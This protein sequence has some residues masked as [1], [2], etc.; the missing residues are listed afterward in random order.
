MSCTKF[1]PLASI[2]S[3]SAF[4]F[5]SLSP[6]PLRLASPL[7]RKQ[8]RSSSAH[9]YGRTVFR[10]PRGDLSWRMTSSPDDASS[11][12]ASA[13]S[14]TSDTL[15]DLEPYQN[16]NNL[17]DQV[18]SAMSADGGLK[19]TVA[20]MRNLLN[21]MMIQHTMNAVP[22]DALGRATLCALMASNGMQEEQMFQITMKGDGPLRGCVAIV[23]GKGEARGYVGNPSL[24]DDFTLKEAI[25]AGTVQVVKNHPSWPR[26]YNGITGIKHGDIDRDVG[27]YLADSEQRS[28]ALA[29][30]TSFNGFLCTAAG[31]YL[32]ERL[33][34]CP[35][36]T[37]SRMER[38]LAKLVEM[39]GSD[40]EALPSNLLLEGKTPL[41]IASVLLDGLGMEPLGQLEPKPSC[42]C[43]EEKLNRSLRLLPRE[44]VDTIWANWSLNPAVNVVRRD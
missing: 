5:P 14:T 10:H 42:E 15:P 38:N 4:Q 40:G 31:G 37:M 21:E 33:P 25:G 41:D 20:T 13:A 28:C 23:T 24:G 27:I 11:T 35:P 43:S 29:A 6:S 2:T 26:P 9:A 12:T 8:W 34:D 7:G 17:D 16:K 36:E 3:C 32:V 1:R 39:N 30:A 22:G 19:V 18:F 44:E